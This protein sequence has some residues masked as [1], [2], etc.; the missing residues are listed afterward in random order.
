MINPDG[1]AFSVIVRDS[2]HE[3]RVWRRGDFLPSA[4]QP[5]YVRSGVG[6]YHEG[7]HL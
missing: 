3:A 7:L 5:S 1:L 6:I 2:S 4:L